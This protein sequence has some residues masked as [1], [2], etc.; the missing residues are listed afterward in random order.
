MP[1]CEQQKDYRIDICRRI[2]QSN[3]GNKKVLR[4]DIRAYT[5]TTTRKAE[6]YDKQTKIAQLCKNCHK[7]HFNGIYM[8]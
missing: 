5:T 6:A 4:T 2:T 7:T 3:I 1:F 8:Q